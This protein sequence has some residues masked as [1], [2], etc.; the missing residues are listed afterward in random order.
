MQISIKKSTGMFIEQATSVL[1]IYIRKYINQKINW[2][3]Y[4][5][6]FIGYNRL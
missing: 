1:K 5:K 3:I 6:C 2:T 4:K